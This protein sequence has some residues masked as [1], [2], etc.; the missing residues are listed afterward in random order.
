MR[1]D[2]SQVQREA[3]L[4]FRDFVHQHITPFAAQWDREQRVSPEIVGQLRAEGYLG[5]PHPRHAGGPMDPVTYGLLTEEIARGCSS[6]RSLL[7]VHDMVA[8]GI[9]RWGNHDLK[10]E[11]GEAV[12]QGQVL[13]ALALSEPQTGSDAAAVSTEA[14][15]DGDEYALTGTKKWITFGQIADL[16]L[17]LARCQGQLAAFV[18]PA[19]TPGLSRVPMTGI[20]GTR[21]SLL[22]ELKLEQCRIPSR[23][24]VGRI[25][26]GF[27]HV[28]SSVLDLGRYSVAWG[29]V[30]I[31]QACLDACLQYTAERKQ[32]GVQLREHQLIQRKLTEMIANTR[33]ARLLCSRA[34]YLRETED[35]GAISETMVAKYFASRI[36]VSAANDAVQLHGANGL[37]EE[38][39]VARYLRDAKVMEVIEGSTEI[40]QITIAKL[41]FAEF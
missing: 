31:A 12:A 13:C 19:S 2:L 20:V 24:L 37:T 23:Y 14:T 22:A 27:S 32:F 7:T 6:V 4:R 15:I 38:Y 18:V 35:P 1:L 36:A 34:G 21:A 41:A 11:F 39:N 8:L 33:A 30:G 40:Q 26:F 5:A 28:V 16:F 10:E 17:V 3:R 9:W 25:G 29:S